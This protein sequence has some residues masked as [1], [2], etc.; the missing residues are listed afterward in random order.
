[1]FKNWR[2]SSFNGALLAA[3]FIPVW[4][5]IAFRIMLSPVHGLFERPNISIALFV[6]DTLQLSAMG[7]V[8]V[9]WLLAVA[10]LTVAAFFA[11]FLLLT[12]VPRVRKAGGCNEALAI[13]LAFGSLISFASMVLASQVHEIE[14]LRLHATELMLLLGTAIVLLVEAPAQSAA[15]VSSAATEPVTVGRQA[16]P[17]R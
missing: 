16:L 15:P 12:S 9:A 11:I 14:A 1:M 8:R 3:Y 13:A 17:A 6:S 4:S 2:L 10:R 7:T 5:I